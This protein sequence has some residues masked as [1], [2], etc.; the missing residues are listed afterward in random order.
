MVTVMHSMSYQIPGTGSVK[1][2]VGSSKNI[3]YL[4]W[5]I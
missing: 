3:I 2:V 5:F 1:R 4:L